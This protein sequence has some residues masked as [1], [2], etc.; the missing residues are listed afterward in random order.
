[1][2]LDDIKE[3][4]I[5]KEKLSELEKQHQRNLEEDKSAQLYKAHQAEAPL[6]E[7]IENVIWKLVGKLFDLLD[8]YTPVR[9][10][11]KSF[12]GKKAILSSVEYSAYSPPH[13]S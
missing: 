7:N 6:L 12:F 11:K 8:C 3:E 5:R 2:K 4:L 9:K 10:F 1:M 13:L